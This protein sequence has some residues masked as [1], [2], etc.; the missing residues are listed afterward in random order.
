MS[1]PLDNDCP[2]CGAEAGQKCVGA[3]GHERAT[4]HRARGSKRN[5][6]PIY[7][8][9]SIPTESPIETL[10][11]ATVLEWTDVHGIGGV[12]ITTQAP[13]GQYRADILIEVGNHKLVVECDGREYHTSPDQVARDKRRDRYCASQG[14]P[15]MRFTGSEIHRDPRGCAAEIGVW[16]RGRW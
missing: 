2:S 4:Y 1:H 16:I 8:D 12:L 5:A 9:R 11:V 14:I 13:V 15:V 10:L 6:H 3:R 7:V